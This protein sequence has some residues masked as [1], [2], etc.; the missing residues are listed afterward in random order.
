MRKRKGN[1]KRKSS[2]EKKNSGMLLWLSNLSKQS[3]SQKFQ[4]KIKLT[5]KSP[6]KLLR[7]FKMRLLMK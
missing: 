3:I 1:F 4:R 2:G 7:R 6:L 5:K